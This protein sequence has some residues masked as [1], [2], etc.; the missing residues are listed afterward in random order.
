[1]LGKGRVPT[2]RDHGLGHAGLG[3]SESAALLPAS[4][5]HR[6]GAWN[7]LGNTG[8]VVIEPAGGDPIQMRSSIGNSSSIAA[9]NLNLPRF[10][11]WHPKGQCGAHV[12]CESTFSITHNND[13][14]AATPHQKIL[15]VSPHLVSAFHLFLVLQLLLSVSCI[16]SPNFL[17]LNHHLESRS[18]F[19]QLSFHVI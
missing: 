17:P 3:P 19:S 16:Y 11:G 14:F 1:M 6:L 4:R 13:H 5:W 15:P 10:W 8:L 7:V 9:T 18:L 12:T 2:D